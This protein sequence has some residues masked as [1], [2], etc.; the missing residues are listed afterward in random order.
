MTVVP[1]RKV[2]PSPD[3]D[4]F[5]S[6]YPRKK[7]K[8]DARKAFDRIKWTPALWE[9][10]LTALE[11]QRKEWS[12]PRFIPYPATYLNQAR[13]EDEPDTPP[14]PCAWTGCQRSGFMEFRNGKVY[15]QNHMAALERGETPVGR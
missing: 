12:D 15:C 8:A 9:Q 14:A 11:W 1:L 13:F 5:W 2:E 3:F 6:I 10:L 4:Q 7:A